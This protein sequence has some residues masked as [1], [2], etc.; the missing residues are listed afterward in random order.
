MY[1]NKMHIYQWIV[2]FII[3]P[4]INFISLYFFV[5]Y[6]KYKNKPGNNISHKHLCILALFDVCYDLLYTISIPK[7]SLVTYTIVGKISYLILMVTSYY[8]LKR[9]YLY[10]HFIGVIFCLTGVFITFAK[11]EQQKEDGFIYIFLFLIGI[12]IQS[13]SSVYKEYFVKNIDDLDIFY[14]N[15]HINGWELLWSCIFFFTIFIKEINP[16]NVTQSNI[17]TYFND[18]FECQ[19]VSC[20]YSLLFLLLS[21]VT[22]VFGILI[23]YK[24]VKDYSS[25]A[26]DLLIT[27]NGPLFLSVM[28]FFIKNKI[29]NLNETENNSYNLHLVDYISI[30]I[31]FIGSIIYFLKKEYTY[32][33][34]SNKETLISNSG[35]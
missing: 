22:T 9:R 12:F 18:A 23:A 6:S 29:I 11:P 4:A 21:Q 14:M 35:L 24:I 3:F 1:L 27:F 31:T 7:M 8:F 25:M 17:N 20:K 15:W 13:I 34:Q 33:N 19:F 32:Q 16:Y 28:Y 30:V 5:I 26:I 10:T 2:P